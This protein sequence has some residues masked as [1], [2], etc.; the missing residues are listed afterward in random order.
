M[1]A[2]KPVDY[3]RAHVFRETASLVLHVEWVRHGL[4]LF[5]LHVPLDLTAIFRHMVNVTES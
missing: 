1:D 5:D 2:E 3:F 4:L